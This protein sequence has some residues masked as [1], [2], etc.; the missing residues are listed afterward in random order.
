M[1]RFSELTGLLAGLALFLGTLFAAHALVSQH[2]P[3]VSASLVED[4]D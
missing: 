1:I 3:E 4:L 2:G